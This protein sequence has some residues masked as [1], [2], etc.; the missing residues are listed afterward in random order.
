GPDGF[1]VGYGKNS[2]AVLLPAFLS[3]YT[4]ENPSKSSTGIF[5]N[6]PLPNWNLK[7]T[8]LMKLGWFKDNFRRFSL[9]HGYRAGYTLGSYSTNYEYVSSP[10][11]LNQ[12]GNYPVENIVNNA[13]LVEQFNP[14]IRV[15]FETKSAFK[16]LA[17]IRKDR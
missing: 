16:I 2:Q 6:I 11:A 15:D 3:A 17:E 8:G 1:P 4:N 5:R 7:Y 10:N 12:F 9:Q 14:L 13:V